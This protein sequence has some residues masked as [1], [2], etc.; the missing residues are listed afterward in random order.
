MYFASLL[1]TFASLSFGAEVIGADEYNFS[2]FRTAR[3]Q[4]RGA[5]LIRLIVV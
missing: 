4:A 1:V 2:A 3:L 5:S